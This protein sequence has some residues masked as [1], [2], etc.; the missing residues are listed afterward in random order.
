M[1]GFSCGQNVSLHKGLHQLGAST[2]SNK[3]LYRSITVVCTGLLG[4]A[5]LIGFR[6]LIV[7]YTPLQLTKSLS[8]VSLS[9]VI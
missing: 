1:A 5:E 8:I 9:L 3:M 2:N 4:A 6:T 7:A